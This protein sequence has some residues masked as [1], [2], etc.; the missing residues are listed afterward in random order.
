[1]K[2]CYTVNVLNNTYFVLILFYNNNKQAA[3]RSNNV[4]V[5]NAFV[6]HFAIN[7]LVWGLDKWF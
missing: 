5:F 4:I 3:F 6:N 7:I 2:F 1:M